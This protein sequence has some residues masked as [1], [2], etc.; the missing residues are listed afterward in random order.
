VNLVD[1]DPWKGDYSRVKVHHNR[2]WANGRY[3]K[4]GIVTGPSSWSD[5]TDTVVRGATVTDNTFS[6]AHF[7]YAIV[8]SSSE[9]FTVQRNKV[10]DDA[11]FSG[12]PGPSCPSAPENSPP[13]PFL[14]NRGSARGSYQSDFVNGEVQHSEKDG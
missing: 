1:Y 12:V 10:A 14:I 9:G 7:G 6:G 11:V 13:T 4:V 2:F 8:V 3:F 5:D